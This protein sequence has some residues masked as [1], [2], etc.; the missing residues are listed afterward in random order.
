L[1]TY[2]RQREGTAYDDKEN[3]HDRATEESSKDLRFVSLL[4]QGES[5]EVKKVMLSVGRTMEQLA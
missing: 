4:I 3:D 2:Q 5:E 1:G